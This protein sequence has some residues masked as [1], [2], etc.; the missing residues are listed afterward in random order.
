MSN[1]FKTI[2]SRN[3]LCLYH[4]KLSPRKCANDPNSQLK[5]VR[6]SGNTRECRENGRAGIFPAPWVSSSSVHIRDYF[7]NQRWPI[8][9]EKKLANLWESTFWWNALLRKEQFEVD[10]WKTFPCLCDFIFTWK[11]IVSSIKFFIFVHLKKLSKSYCK[12]FWTEF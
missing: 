7:K 9:F 10:I 8:G 5:I 6:N 12:F 11:K 2:P 3:W 1:W 4:R